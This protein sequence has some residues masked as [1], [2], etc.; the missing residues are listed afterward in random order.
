MSASIRLGNTA[1]PTASSFPSR[2]RHSRGTRPLTLA[3]PSKR[4]SPKRDGGGPRRLGPFV[5]GGEMCHGLNCFA[6][7]CGRSNRHCRIGRLGMIACLFRIM[8]LVSFLVF[9]GLRE[10]DTAS[11][12]AIGSQL[13]KIAVA[14]RDPRQ[15][16]W[17]RA[18]RACRLQ[19]VV[20][21][22][23]SHQVS[24]CQHGNLGLFFN[25]PLAGALWDFSS[26]R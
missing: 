22:D 19:R 7:P 5:R 23:R 2:S 10:P 3:M 24:E 9:G 20:I 25:A 26:E 14:R 15:T 16:Q 6:P 18:D 11:S 21:T 13:S 8:L 1:I 12:A 17:P 4:E